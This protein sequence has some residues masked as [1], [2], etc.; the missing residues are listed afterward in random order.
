[1]VGRILSL[2]KA[3][4]LLRKPPGPG[5]ATRRRRQRPYAVR[6]PKDYQARA[7][8]DIVQIDTLDARLLPGII[9][10]HCTARDVVSR[11]DVL[12]AH[13]RAT[14]AM[15]AKFLDG[16]QQ[17]LPLPFKVIQVDGGS[18]FQADFEAACRQQGI[19]LFVLPPRSPKLNGHVERAQRAH[20][21][22]FYQLHDTRSVHRRLG[23]SAFEPGPAAVGAGVQHR[24]PSPV[25][26]RM[27]PGRV[28][29]H[30]PPATHNR[31]R[32]LICTER[33]QWVSL[34]V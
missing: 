29:C 13:T 27:H 3:R 33:V 11:W 8:G 17:R 19:K 24:A 7:P 25:A 23:D 16:L 15:A 4:G 26:G 2:L 30:P 34:P 14:A 6:K 12:S 10:K 22:E 18:E 20:T 21:E 28:S 1:M 9:L 31:P 32:L 5:L